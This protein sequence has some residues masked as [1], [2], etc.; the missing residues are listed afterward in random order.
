M[1]DLLEKNNGTYTVKQRT[2][3]TGNSYKRDDERYK[4]IK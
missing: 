4:V 3:S 1:L 2:L